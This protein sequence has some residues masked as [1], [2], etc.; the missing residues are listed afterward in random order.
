M[1]QATLKLFLVFIFTVGFVYPFF[2]TGLTQLAFPHQANGSIIYK[3][4]KPIGSMLIGQKFTHDKYFWGR[5]S[6]SDYGTLPSKGSNLSYGSKKLRK[7]MDERV[8]TLKKAHGNDHEPPS[9]LIY[10][11]GSGLD[12]DITITGALY[13]LDRV[14]KARNLSKKQ[15]SHLKFQIDFGTRIYWRISSPQY[16]NVLRLNLILDQLDKNDPE[17]DSR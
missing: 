1:I 13:Q 8:K 9:P 14:A 10:A 4:G 2:I 17:T 15:I 5:P 7:E 11:S 3:D 6:A 12:P 16:L